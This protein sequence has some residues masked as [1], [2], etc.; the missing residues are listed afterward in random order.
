METP[1]IPRI[2]IIALELST[3]LP[4]A[5]PE[6]DIL[7]EICLLSQIPTLGYILLEKPLWSG[8]Y[9]GIPVGHI[10]SYHQ[11]DYVKVILSALSGTSDNYPAK[12][13]GILFPQ[14]TNVIGCKLDTKGI[15]NAITQSFVQS[16]KTPGVRATLSAINEVYLMLYKGSTADE[17]LIEKLEKALAETLQLT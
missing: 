16:H 5:I 8:R 6:V 1:Q 12:R 4:V 14:A 11:T 15:M 7:V 9:G 3:G 2:Q 17:E 13:V 10:F